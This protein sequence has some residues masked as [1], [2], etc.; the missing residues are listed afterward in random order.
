MI[1]PNGVHG[2]NMMSVGGQRM[3]DTEKDQG[4]GFVVTCL[5][6]GRSCLVHREEIM[7][8]DWQTCPL[9]EER[10]KEC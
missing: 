2:S 7:R 3:A 8:G 9:C 10:D 5:H 6:C 4:I 1:K